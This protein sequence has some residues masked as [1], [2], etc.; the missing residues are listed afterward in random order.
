MKTERTP[1]FLMANLGSEMVRLFQAKKAKQFDMAKNSAERA[2]K[3][4]DSIVIHQDVGQGK[5]EAEILR[6]IIKDS[7]SE[8][9]ELHI[10]EDDLNSYFTP[11][12][13]RVL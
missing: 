7:L 6:M 11:F 5:K 9:P 10:S 2:Y 13:K 3:I 8:K 1:A 12:A 4:I